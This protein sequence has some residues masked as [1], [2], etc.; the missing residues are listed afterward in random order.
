MTFRIFRQQMIPRIICGDTDMHPH[1]LTC[2]EKSV[3]V[4]N[5]APYA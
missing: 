4:L 1:T 5:T 2:I 3:V